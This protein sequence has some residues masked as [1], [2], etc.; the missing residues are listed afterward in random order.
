MQG[1]KPTFYLSR[2]THWRGFDSDCK[3]GT[4]YCSNEETTWLMEG[5]IAIYWRAGDL[6]QIHIDKFTALFYVA[7]PDNERSYW[8]DNKNA[9]EILLEWNNREKNTAFGSRENCRAPLEYG[10]IEYGNILHRNITLRFKWVWNYFLS[11]S[12][13]WRSLIQQKYKYPP[14]FTIKDL[15]IP[16]SGGLWKGICSTFLLHPATKQIALIGVWKSTGDGS[17]T[18]FWHHIWISDSS[19]KSRF[20][21]LFLLALDHAATVASYSIWDGL[22]WTWNFSWLSPLRERDI[23]A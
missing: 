20:P 23:E 3:L 8:Q 7:L 11:P 9:K 12:P 6:D 17:S 10:W 18:L 13:L 5:D 14:E 21:H 2:P 4:N 19:L 15:S 22:N 16:K 1:W